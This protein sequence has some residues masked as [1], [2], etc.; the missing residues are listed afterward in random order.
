MKANTTFILLALAL[1]SAA[2][3]LFGDES[4]RNLH[5]LRDNLGRQHEKNTELS[6][7]VSSLRREV[8]GLQHDDRVLEKAARNELGMSRPDEL[9]FVFG[10]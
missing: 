7:Q 10:D 2:V 6:K 5:S 8:Y 4:Y 1:I 9:I 3:S